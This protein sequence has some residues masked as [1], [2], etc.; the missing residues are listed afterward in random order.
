MVQRRNK[1]NQRKNHTATRSAISR[2]STG[3]PVSKRNVPRDPPMLP[4]VLA[5]PVRTRF[6]LF[7]RNSTNQVG[8]AVQLGGL[9]TAPNSVF[10]YFNPLT[11][12]ISNSGGLT[13]N[14]IFTAAAMRLFGVDVTTDPGGANFVTTDYAIQKTTL[15]GPTIDVEGNILLTVDFG[16]DVPGFVGRDSG[17]KNKRAVVSVSP[18][19]LSWRKLVVGDTSPAINYNTGLLRAPN[20][21]NSGI[22]FPTQYIGSQAWPI[23]VLDITVLVR[24]SVISDVSSLSNRSTDTVF[25]SEDLEV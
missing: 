13:Y 21:D 5:Y 17:A 1:R 22:N 18:P 7:S 24:R 16:G 10:H 9:P 23:G 3:V 12:V 14:E 19:R 25:T 6:L 11:G 2:I 4:H 15:Y 20:A 8:Y